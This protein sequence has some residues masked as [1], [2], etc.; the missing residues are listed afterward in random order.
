[1]EKVIIIGCPGSGKST[2]A[3]A[4][5]KKTGLPLYHLDLLNWNA[6]RTVVPRPVFLERLQNTIIQSKWIIDGN[7]GSTME[8]RINACDTIIFLDYPLD[9]CLAGVQARKGQE[10]PDMPWIEDPE[11]DEDLEFMDFIRRYHI[12]SRPAV[13]ELFKKYPDKHILIF[14]TREEANNYLSHFD[15][16]E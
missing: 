5:Q 7:Y 13:M 16:E 9:V 4:L 10:R 1:M 12:D 11:A 3:R 8:L 6:D 2:F 14:H 15:S